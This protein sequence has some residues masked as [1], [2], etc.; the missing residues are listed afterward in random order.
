MFGL[1]MLT[2]RP[3]DCLIEA[4]SPFV[5]GKRPRVEESDQFTDAK[6]ATTASPGKIDHCRLLAV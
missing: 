3:L 2:Q 6:A 5:L 1:E 4:L